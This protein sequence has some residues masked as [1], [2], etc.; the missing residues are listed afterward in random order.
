MM[1]RKKSKDLS[2]GIL[3][4]QQT[5][6]IGNIQND[7]PTIQQCHPE[8]N[9]TCNP[10]IGKTHSTIHRRSEESNFIARYHVICFRK[11]AA[12]DNLSRLPRSEERREGKR[13]DVGGSR[14]YRRTK[15]DD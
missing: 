2:G 15:E 8:T 14:R 3:H 5:P 12:N 4:V 9:N 6:C 1:M 11:I 13:V 10:E 7:R